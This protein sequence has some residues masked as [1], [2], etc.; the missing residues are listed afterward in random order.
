MFSISTGASSTRMPTA[1]ASPPRVMTLSVWP[2]A[3]MTMREQRID[4]G[5]D[6][7]TIRVLRQLPRNSK[8]IVAVR[9][10]AMIASFT[11]PPTAAWTKSDCHPLDNIQGRGTAAFQH[12]EQRRAPPVLI[13]DI[14]LHGSAITHLR[15]VADV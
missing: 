1:S 7:A 12:R 11:T 6:S 14:A 2:M 8:I 13:D 15:H 5:I 9:A 10:A 3:P 4:S